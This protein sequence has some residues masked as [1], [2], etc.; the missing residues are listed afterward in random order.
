MK[1]LQPT[2]ECPL[3]VPCVTHLYGIKATVQVVRYKTMVAKVY[4][5]LLALA[6]ELFP[7]LLLCTFLIATIN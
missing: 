3:S 4:Q 6:T 7:I 2:A 5:Q 1:K